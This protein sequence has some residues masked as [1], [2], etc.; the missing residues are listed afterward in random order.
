MARNARLCAVVD[1]L[2][3][4]EEVRGAAEQVREAP[5]KLSLADAD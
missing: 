5:E 1:E 4:A 3:S 2:V